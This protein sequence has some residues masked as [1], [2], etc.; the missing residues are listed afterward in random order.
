MHGSHGSHGSIHGS[1]DGNLLR[2]W[3]FLVCEGVHVCCLVRRHGNWIGIRALR[4]VTGL[5]LVD[6]IKFDVLRIL[7]QA[8]KCCRRD[9]FQ[10]QLF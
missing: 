3:Y 8:S 6:V 9:F 5:C 2:Y 4:Y 10:G 1:I 7:L